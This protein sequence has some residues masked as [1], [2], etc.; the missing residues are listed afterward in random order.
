M[1]TKSFL[2]ITGRWSIAYA[3]SAL[4]ALS[5]CSTF[6]GSV[7]PAAMGAATQA[8]STYTDY[9]VDVSTCGLSTDSGATCDTE[10][11][12]INDQRDI[13][14]NDI[15][16]SNLRSGTCPAPTSGVRTNATSAQTSCDCPIPSGVGMPAGYP[17]Y[18]FLAQFTD[19]TYETL[20]PAIYPYHASSQ[21]LSAISNR[22][23]A[24]NGVNST[25][26]VG[27]VNNFINGPHLPATVGAVDNGGLVIPG[28][29]N[30]LVKANG[31]G[32]NKCIGGAVDSFLSIDNFNNTVGFS[33]DNN[34]SGTSKP[35]DVQARSDIPGDNQSAITVSFKAKSP[36]TKTSSA[37]YTAIVAS[38]LS[39]DEKWIVG[40][41]KAP[42]GTFGWYAPYSIH[43]STIT[44]TLLCYG[45]S[46]SDPTAFT[47]VRDN[48]GSPVIVGWYVAGTS[49]S[50]KTHG[51]V[52]TSP[53]ASTPV[54]KTVD[55]QW[56]QGYSV[57][58]G[59]NDNGDICGWYKGTGGYYHGFVG[60]VAGAPR[61]T[62]LP[63][64]WKRRRD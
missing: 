19:S 47:G 3:A 27:C 29:W 14:G 34:E 33:N 4:L 28:L 10:V 58:S 11:T 59:T 18:S 37:K 55:A 32:N 12:G 60:L 6:S 9:K 41:A 23:L 45:Q 21:Y 7:N 50:A 57:I 38:G 44:A 49:S 42:S 62:K 39:S 48:G 53:T 26:E 8:S 36:C 51:L 52:L 61:G 25:I 1:K 64:D 20:V 22:L 30:T 15:I 63:S 56:T 17:W 43:S 40:F 24:A 54:W 31:N 5:A 35:C 13:V 2:T 16:D 46:K